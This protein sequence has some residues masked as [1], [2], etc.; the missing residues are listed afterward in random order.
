MRDGRGL[1]GGWAL[2]ITVLVLLALCVPAL[3]G[4]TGDDQYGPPPGPSDG[5]GDPSGNGPDGG[6]SASGSDGC[7]SGEV[8]N[9]ETD[10]C[11]RDRDCTEDFE[12]Q[13]E[14]QRFFESRGG[15]DEDP[16]DLDDDSPEP[17]DGVA[18]ESLPSEDEDS[19][20][21][22][23]GGVDSGLGGTAANA[24]AE[25]GEGLPLAFSGGALT[26]LVLTAGG[27]AVSR[28]AT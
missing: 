18:C 8:R 24:S 6:G 11:E 26:L 10:D 28:R 20:S 15:P 23:E 27:L 2:L 9:P 16:H 3:A 17:D 22:P 21:A 1:R 7:G 5:G 19:G 4:G 13:E 12:F 14:A 25:A